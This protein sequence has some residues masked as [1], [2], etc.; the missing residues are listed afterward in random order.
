MSHD[1]VVI[2]AM[3]QGRGFN[4][5]AVAI[6]LLKN[7]LAILPLLA[8]VLSVGAVL[9]VIIRAQGASWQLGIVTID[10][11]IQIAVVAFVVLRWR[12]RLQAAQGPKVKVVP[13]LCRI[14]LMSVAASFVLTTPFFGIAMSKS[15]VGA[16]LFTTLLILGALWCLR[17]YLFFAVTGM[18]G[19]PLASSMARSIELSRVNMS[20]IVR[21]LIAPIALTIVCSTLFLMPYPDGRS[22][23]WIA[24][25]AAC[26]GIFWILSTY[27]GLALALTLFG[28]GEWRA[29]GLSH[30]R[31]DRLSTL[32]AQGGKTLPKYL[33]PRFGFMMLG[34]ALFFWI[35][36]FS[37]LSQLAPAATVAIRSVRV[38]DYKVTVVLDIEDREFKY[39][40]FQPQAFFLASKTGT[41]QSNGLVAASQ[42]SVT[43]SGVIGSIKSN[44]G[45]PTTLFLTFSSPKTGAVLQSLDNM[46]LWYRLAPLLPIPPEMLKMAEALP[47]TSTPST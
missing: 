7:D 23:P 11:V 37:R 30:Y 6:G 34:V 19:M 46:W 31:S 43:A 35:G 17:V 3:G 22:L 1:T 18:L 38:E 24:A 2:D 10:R 36:N 29:A 12:R 44:E 26:E 16:V 4:P 32:E 27:T 40:G 21:S 13:A 8:F 39:R 14:G 45:E 9:D 47:A 5:R 25:A 41:A 33:A 20:A 15:V 28:E 42:D